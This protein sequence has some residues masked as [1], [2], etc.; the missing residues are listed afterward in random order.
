MLRVCARQVDFI[1][2]RDNLQVI[3]Q[4]QINVCQGLRL[5][6]LRS[7]NNQQRT[8]AGCQ[9]TR[10]LIGEVD[11]A[12]SVDK[13]QHI[14]LAIARLINAAYRLRL[15]GNAAL[16]LQIHGV[17]NL[18]LHLTF[19]QGSCI[20]NQAVCQRRFAMIYMGNNRKVTNMVLLNHSNVAFSFVDNN[21]LVLIIIPFSANACKLKRAPT[22]PA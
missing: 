17:E 6:A 14:L 8:L 10:N 9:R 18:C 16:A 12:G 2:N 7:V 19:A 4:R 3:I 11:V 1:D 20:F 22:A 21:L 15:D 5:N 13:V